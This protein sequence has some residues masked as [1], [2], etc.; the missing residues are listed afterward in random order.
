MGLAVSTENVEEV[1]RYI[2]CGILNTPFSFLGS[3]VGGCMSW[4]KSWDEVIDKMKNV[5]EKMDKSNGTVS[6]PFP[7][8]FTPCD[9][10]EVERDK[11]SIGLNPKA[12]KDWVKEICVSH[13]VNFL[14]LQETKMEDI[15]LIDVKCCWGHYAFEYMYS[16]AVGNSGGILCVWEKSAFKKNNSTISD[17]F[18]MIGGS[19]LCSGV[20]LLIISVYAPQEYAEKKMLWDY[21]I[22]VISKCDRE[23]I[24][25]GD[26]NEV[27]FKNE[28]YGQILDGPFILNELLQWC[29]SK[30][31]QS[32]I[33]K[34]DFEKA[35]DSVH[36]NYLDDI[37][38][39]FGF[40]ENGVGGFKDVLDLQGLHISF[41][42]V[43][44]ADMFKGIAL[45]SSL[46]LSHMLYVDDAVFVGQWSEPNIDTIVHVLD[47]FYRAP[48]LRIN[49]NKSKLMGISVDGD[50]VEQATL[51]IGC[52]TLKSHF[53]YLDS[54]VGGLI[55]TL[56][57][58][59]IKAI[60][61]EDGKIG[62]KVKATYSSIWL[63][64]VHVLE[65]IKK[66]SI[67]VVNC[68]QKKLGNGDNTSFWEDTWR[69]DVTFKTLYPILYAL[70]TIK[71]VTVASKLSYSSLDYSFRRAPRGGVEQSQFLS[72]KLIDD[73]TLPEV[74]SKSR[75][76]KAVSIKV[77]ILAWKVKLD[78]LPTRINISRRGFNS[79][80]LL[81]RL[82]ELISLRRMSRSGIESEQWGHL[83]DSLEG[84]M[85]NPSEDRWPWDLNGSGEFSVASARRYIDNNRLP[86]I[87]FKTRWIKEVPI[88]VNVH[89]WKALMDAT[90][91]Q[92]ADNIKH[93]TPEEVRKINIPNDFTPEEEEAAR[94][95][96]AWAFE[97]IDQN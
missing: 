88:K 28:R 36:W 21:L 72:M 54:E 82:Y 92:M 44:D 63:D 95:E 47:C 61:D 74:F 3:K 19:W 6:I 90:C 12:K 31:K 7:P 58:R 35:Y 66:Q 94:K 68:I 5:E 46:H 52:V 40:G 25:M 32:L 29:K 45:D 39:K 4:I 84:V 73:K 9:E 37:L 14:T 15:F 75:W 53:S 62:K 38:K 8:G 64:I 97:N 76:S 96:D 83:L 78:C 93:K 49:M 57:V 80:N 18:V 79:N 56:W 42:M 34:V 69:G 89:A 30:K 27:R 70:E 48:G 60:H 10:T 11:K 33:F 23:V 43:V 65:V 16:P 86:D 13:K 2:G 51:K 91:Q 85:L 59:T 81:S 1:T 20:N 87:S 71:D 55:S 26:F 77:D 22:H 50:I 17:Y 41:Q 24:V 67:N